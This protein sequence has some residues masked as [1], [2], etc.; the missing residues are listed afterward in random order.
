MARDGSRNVRVG[1]FVSIGTALLIITMYL[2][3]D[4]QNLFGSTFTVSAK[5]HNVNGLMVGNNVRFGGIN[6]G[7]IKSIGI[8]NDS[9][10]NVEMTIEE[11][12]KEFIKK[13][14]LAS[15]GT[16]G[17]MGN[18][19]INLNSVNVKSSA[20]EE[21][22]I[23]ESLRPIETDEML[24]TLNRTN[25]EISVIVKNLKLITEKVNSPNTLWS[26]LMDTIIAENVKA[27]VVNFKIT[28][29]KS[30]IITGDLSAIVKDIKSGK[31]SVGAFLTDTSFAQKINQT[32]VNIQVVSDS[33]AYITGDLK[34]ITTKIKNGD[35]AIGTILMDT[36]FVHNL[37]QS[38][39][40]LKNGTQGFDDNMEALKHNF[41]LRKYFKKQEKEKE[42]KE[43]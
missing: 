2:I 28:T 37:N 43:Q 3:G 6:V 19:L 20:I 26:I 41:L 10:I 16:D 33:L 38:M 29:N 9:T 31:G 35:G 4:K 25:E 36:T 23:L 18:K 30:A 5:F 7:T 8:V 13:N 32:I 11:H 27:A 34:N 24:R 12:V 39:L 1:I 40:N 42:S 14:T 21:G 17:L 22:D 15:V